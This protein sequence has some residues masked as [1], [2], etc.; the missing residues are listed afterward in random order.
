VS[1]QAGESGKGG[2]FPKGK[3]CVQKLPFQRTETHIAKKDFE[4][5]LTLDVD[6]GR[7]RITISERFHLS[8]APHNDVVGF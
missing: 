6:G 7:V 2:F 8:V 1:Q 3:N 5:R 4:K